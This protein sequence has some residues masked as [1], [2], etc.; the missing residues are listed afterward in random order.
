VDLSI[1]QKNR[2]MACGFSVS[3]GGIGQFILTP[4]YQTKNRAIFAKK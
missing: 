3:G 1:D 2:N 4:L